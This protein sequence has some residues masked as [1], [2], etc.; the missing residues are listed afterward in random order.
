MS[1]A[2]SASPESL[3]G[4]PHSPRISSQEGSECNTEYRELRKRL[5]HLTSGA[6]HH[7][8]SAPPCSSIEESGTT[9]D[10]LSET[11]KGCSGNGTYMSEMEISTYDSIPRNS[12][13]NSFISTEV[14][15]LESSYSS[16]SGTST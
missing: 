2:T 13:I 14:D 4:G 11:T 6:Q 12:S 10:L 8:N 5:G 15:T 3:H 9:M 7:R 16:L 1:T